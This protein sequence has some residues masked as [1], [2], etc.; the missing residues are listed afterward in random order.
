MSTA[1]LTSLAGTPKFPNLQKLHLED[2]LEDNPQV[3]DN[4]STLV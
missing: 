4:I 3:S 1:S 2:A